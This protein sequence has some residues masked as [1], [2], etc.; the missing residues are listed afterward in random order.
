[1]RTSRTWLGALLIAFTV[2]SLLFAQAQV[3]FLQQRQRMGGLGST[4]NQG[5]ADSA[6]DPHDCTERV[7]FI[8]PGEPVLLQ[9]SIYR[10]G[11]P[12]REQREKQVAKILGLDAE[13]EPAW[14]DVL[15]SRDFLSGRMLYA[16][17]NP[18]AMNQLLKR[19]DTNGDGRADR[20][21]L[22]A[23]TAQNLGPALRFAAG[24]VPSSN[25]F[26]AL[27][28]TNDDQMIDANELSAAGEQIL[29]RDQDDNEIVDYIEISPAPA[30]GRRVV[31]E[32]SVPGRIQPTTAVQ[33][34]VNTNWA[35]LREYLVIAY[36]KDKSLPANAVGRWARLDANDDGDLSAAE[37]GA[38]LAAEPHLR[39]ELRLGNDP[40]RVGLTVQTDKVEAQFSQDAMKVAITLPQA[41]LEIFAADT[42]KQAL[43]NNKQN[44]MRFFASRDADKNG[45]LDE[46]EFT[47][48]N[49]NAAATFKLWD[50][51][52]DGKIYIEEVEAY[53]QRST[54]A[55]YGRLTASGANL[56]AGLF[57]QLDLD[58]DGRIDLREIKSAEAT[59]RKNDANG[60]GE[61]SP[62][63]LPPLLRLVVSQG[64][65]ATSLLDDRYRAYRMQRPAAN[66]PG[67]AWFV[68][69]D[70]NSDGEISQREFIGRNEQFEL[71]DQNGDDFIERSEAESVE[72]RDAS[73]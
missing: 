31:V 30:Y 16:G 1:M 59:L 61:L 20:K 19:F 58:N 38:L 4:L 18:N 44:A 43:A 8:A 62:N 13:G 6:T 51:D 26:T 70:T 46:K 40:Q 5:D 10:D 60:D 55:A 63:E 24:N 25:V 3:Q 57:S 21:E 23:A 39:A 32:G 50:A 69:M 67:P 54:Q 71:L 64:G 73:E 53:Y 52:E 27:I 49:Q 72:Q 34:R 41:R 48:G 66:A 56:G 2:P 37:L 35:Q 65:N 9:I 12:Y 36:G 42:T 7:L 47:Q 45:Y 22:Y 29:R 68:H 17:R 28:D 14:K 33:L 11:R 15:A